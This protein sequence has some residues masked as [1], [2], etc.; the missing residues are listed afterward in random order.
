MWVC[1]Y[2]TE[3]DGVPIKGLHAQRILNKKCQTYFSPAFYINL[4]GKVFDLIHP[5]QL[6]AFLP[7]AYST[8]NVT[9]SV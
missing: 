4:S 6:D 5:N 8:Y 3:L 7:E 2:V 9:L 1:V